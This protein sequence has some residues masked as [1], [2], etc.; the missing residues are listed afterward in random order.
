MH[1]YL[2]RL[3]AVFTVATTVLGGLC[4][5]AALTDLLHVSEPQVAATLES[6]DGLTVRGNC[7]Q[8]PLKQEA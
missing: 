5:L 6:I 4:A 3:N 8:F 2:Y 7:I 1:T